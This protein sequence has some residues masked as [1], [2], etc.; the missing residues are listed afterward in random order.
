MR[1]KLE[2]ESPSWR[3]WRDI[4]LEALKIKTFGMVGKH[5]FEAIWPRHN[6]PFADSH[7]VEVSLGNSTR[8]R[9]RSEP[10]GN[11][12][13]VLV[14]GL[15]VYRYDRTMVDYYGFVRGDEQKLK[16]PKL[17]AAATVLSQ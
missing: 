4:F 3:I 6:S 12:M 17:M 11:V 1:T 7:M 2:P 16:D 13:L 14:P 10:S 5:I 8:H 15:R 9:P